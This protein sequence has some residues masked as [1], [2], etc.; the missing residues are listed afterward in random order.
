[1][2]GVKLFFMWEDDALDFFETN[3]II[4]IFNWFCWNK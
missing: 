2:E 1:M 3:I 4:I